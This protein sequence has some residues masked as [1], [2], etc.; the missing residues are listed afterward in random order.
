MISLFS[1][2]LFLLFVGQTR[3][4]QGELPRAAYYG[5]PEVGAD[6][7]QDWTVYNLC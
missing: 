1:L 2:F 4:G 3:R 6:S 5:L 7:E